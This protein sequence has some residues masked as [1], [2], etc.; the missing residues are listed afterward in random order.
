[1]RR[2]APV[3]FV[4]AVAALT[5]T[6]TAARAACG[7]NFAAEIDAADVVFAGRLET[8]SP[9][10]GLPEGYRGQ[11]D[12]EATFVVERSFRGVRAGERVTV[13]WGG[14]RERVEGPIRGGCQAPSLEPGRSTT[15]VVIARRDET[16]V[17]IVQNSTSSKR[18]DDSPPSRAFVARV[19]RRTARH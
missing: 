17:L 15:F 1:M 19:A 2:I 3:L 10:G 11:P 12:V 18:I 16:G 5:P 9:L 13:R 8:A 7:R 6:L 14:W 4:L